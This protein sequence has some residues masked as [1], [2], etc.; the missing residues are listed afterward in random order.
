VLETPFRSPQL[1]LIDLGPGEWLLY[2]KIPDRAP[3]HRKRRIPGIVQLPLLDLSP[4]DM[5]VGAEEGSS[6]RRPRPHLHLVGEH[7]LS[8][9]KDQ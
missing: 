2:W 1:T 4:H 5:A 8:A 7:Q 9:Q 3:A 6:A